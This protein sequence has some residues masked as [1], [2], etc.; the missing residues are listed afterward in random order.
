MANSQ[1]D[2]GTLLPMS[3]PFAKNQTLAHT[4]RENALTIRLLSSA[5]K[6][7]RAN[8][9]TRS[10][11]NLQKVRGVHEAPD[12]VL[13]TADA[14]SHPQTA[15]ISLETLCSIQYTEETVVD[16][17]LC[18]ALP[19]EE[20]VD[21]RARHTNMDWLVPLLAT[22]ATRIK[23]HT[24]V[25]EDPRYILQGPSSSDYDAKCTTA[26]SRIHPRVLPAEE[27]RALFEGGHGT[28]P[29]L[30]YAI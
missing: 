9:Y 16:G 24:D 14:G 26:P 19:T 13:V 2:T 5:A 21:D 11:G 25:S 30:I 3:A 27:T 15:Q 20:R 10:F 8:Q 17:T 18:S 12:I 1:S 23:R 6:T 29:D 4:L 28:T 7:R 22:D